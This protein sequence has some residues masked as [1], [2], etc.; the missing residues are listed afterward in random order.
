MKIT[1]RVEKMT[2]KSRSFVTF[3]TPRYLNDH[4]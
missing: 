2:L 4:P 3:T 1:H